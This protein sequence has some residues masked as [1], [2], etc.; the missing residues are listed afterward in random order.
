[1]EFMNEQRKMRISKF[2]NKWVGLSIIAVFALSNRA[3]A[4]E[5]QVV[6]KIIAKVDENIILKSE[7]EKSYI[8]F[9][10][11][12]QARTFDGDARCLILQSFIEGKIMLAMAEIDSTT[13]SE[14]RV[15]YELQ[16]RMQRVIQQYGS[17]QA[18]LQ[19]FG[20]TIDQ[21]MDELRPSVQEQLL[22]KEQE[23]FIL[24]DVKVTPSDI[25]R[26]F[27]TIPSDSLPLYSREYE[28][29]MIVRSPVANKAA[30]QKVIDRLLEA[31][32]KLIN[33]GGNFDLVALDY[34]EGPTK[35]T[36]GNLGFQSRGNM[37]PAY[38]AAAL[39]LKV[40]EYSMPV[41]SS[42]GIHLIQLLGRRGNEYD[43]RHIIIVPKPSEQDLQD[44]KNSLDSLRNAINTGSISFEEAAQQFSDDEGT[45]RNGG[46]I[47]GPTG[48]NRIPADNMDPTLFFALDSLEVGQISR[49]SFVQLPNSVAIRILYF[50]KEIPPHK[51]NLKDDY[52]KLK[53]AT[54][55][56]KKGEKRNEYLDAKI[57]E[58]YIEI[59]PEY[60]RCG[61][62]KNN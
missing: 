35:T 59:D 13:V 33:Q 36:G 8:N 50:K 37:D 57:L 4:Q 10:S 58:V 47:S 52:E 41:E 22:I 45:K 5:G 27:N 14:S 56:M 11:S 16:G 24:A 26:F 15:D 1:M 60:N 34:S 40:G 28:A 42:F 18:I 44:V 31:R 19:A 32:D 7:L 46:F 62:I 29:G 61:I 30:K 43:T 17:E 9:L 51:A 38:E 39:T 3:N 23:D 20:K 55:Q 48:S 53:N 25:K 21:F 2:L 54:M 6:D 49:P 12:E